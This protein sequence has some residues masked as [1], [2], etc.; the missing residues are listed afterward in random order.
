LGPQV[1]PFIFAD[2]AAGGGPWFVALESITHEDPIAL[3]HRMSAKK[4]RADWI[5]WGIEHG[6]VRA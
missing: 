3:E 6:Y 4:M 5:K 1:L 2:L